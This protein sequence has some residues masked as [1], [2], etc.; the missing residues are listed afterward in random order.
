MF[1]TNFPCIPRNNYFDLNGVN[2]LMHYASDISQMFDVTMFGRVKMMWN[3][4]C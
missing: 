2:L 1:L 4:R 3:S